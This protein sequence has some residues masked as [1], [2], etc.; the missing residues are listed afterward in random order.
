MIF[1]ACFNPNHS[2]MAKLHLN[3]NFHRI[4]WMY[5]SIYKSCQGIIWTQNLKNLEDLIHIATT[6]FLTLE[7]LC[8]PCRFKI[9]KFQYPSLT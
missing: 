7:V 1:K 6:Y 5:S 3:P 4:K 2:M 9:C 8:T